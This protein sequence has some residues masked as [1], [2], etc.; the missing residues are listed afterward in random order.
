MYF[1]KLSD[2]GIKLNG[3]GN[4]QKVR[5]PQCSDGRKNK[6]DKPLSVNLTTGEY[7]CHNC[8]W[9]GNVRTFLPKREFKAYQKPPQH[10]IQ[11]INLKEQIIGW[12]KQRGISHETLNKF[13]IFAK[14]E[15]MPQTQKEESCI[16][17]PYMRDGQIVNVKF[18]D[19]AKNFKMVKDA[20]LIFYNLSSIGDKK[21]CI[22]TEGEI[23]CMAVYEAGVGCEPKSNDDGVLDNEELSKWAIVS[24]PNGASNGSQ[25]LEYLDNC[26]EWFIGLHE[27]IIATDGDKAGEALQQELIRRL[28]VER[29]KTISYPIEECVPLKE[30]GK[31]RCKD[32]NEVLLYLGKEVVLNVLN[33]SEHIPVEGVYEIDDIF[34]SMLEN[35]K[36]GVQLAPTTRFPETDD[37][38]RWKKGDVALF[39][40]YAN[41]GKTFYVIQMMLTKSIWD[42]WKW[43]VFCPENYPANDFYDDIVEMYVGKW[44]KDMTEDEYTEACQFIG[45]HIFYVYPEDSHDIHSIHEKFRYLVLKKGIDGVLVDPFNQLDHNQKGYQREDIYLSEILK[46]IKRFALLN[47]ISYNIVAHPKNPHYQ[48]G[49]VL[50]VVDMYDIHG[51]SMFGNKVDLLISYHRPRFHEDKNSPQVEIY[52][53][54]VKRKRTGGKLG[55]F[56]LTLDWKKKRYMQED[57]YVPCDPIGAKKKIV[58][59]ETYREAQEMWLPYKDDNGTDVGF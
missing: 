22:I 26:A 54:K 2:L 28:G 58:K 17:F 55:S 49:K 39:T 57:G 4:S 33:G 48:E 23:D 44:L 56:P 21:H 13:M 52:V 19:G 31:R 11:N 46:D 41:W 5:C 47:A 6:S 36:K 27:I 18:R 24:V 45:R 32:L 51:G 1:D 16:G 40:G 20:E 37:Y 25:K 35:F 42:G 38:W 59:Q 12:F 29:C 50:P 15:W 8:S 34:A 9:K 14:N 3:R 7:N 10:L 53:Q 30:G 43:G